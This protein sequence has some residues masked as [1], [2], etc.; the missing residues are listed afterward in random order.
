MTFGFEK[1]ADKSKAIKL[2]A[3]MQ[4]AIDA[5]S[6]KNGVAA[7]RIDVK[8]SSVVIGTPSGG[9]WV[10][11][12]RA[13]TYTSLVTDGSGAIFLMANSPVVQPNGDLIGGL[14]DE[15]VGGVISLSSGRDMVV[16]HETGHFL[17]WRSNEYG[18]DD[19]GHSIDPNNIMHKPSPSPGYID[20]QYYKKLFDRSTPIQ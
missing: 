16:G 9:R 10:N 2:V 15:G 20:G 1:G 12:V 8:F 11:S 4:G 17:G 14:S 19:K 6:V 3:N 13:S 7:I 18:Q 5:Y